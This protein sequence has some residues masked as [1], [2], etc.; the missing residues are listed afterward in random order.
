MKIQS[1][2]FYLWFLPGPQSFILVEDRMLL[3][4]L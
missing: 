2:P 3:T 1:Q 4:Y